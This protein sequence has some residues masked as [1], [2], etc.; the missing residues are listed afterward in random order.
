MGHVGSKGLSVI[1]PCDRFCHCGQILSNHEQMGLAAAGA[2][3][4]Y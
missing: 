1:S 3:E 4:A 2:A